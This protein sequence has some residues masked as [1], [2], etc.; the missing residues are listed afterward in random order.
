MGWVAATFRGRGYKNI[1]LKIPFHSG[2]L[3]TMHAVLA[4]CKLPFDNDFKLLRWRSA[5]LNSKIQFSCWFSSSL[6][7][8]VHLTSTFFLQNAT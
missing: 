8:V 5:R 4:L 7:D 1:A 2:P 6:H 3:Q